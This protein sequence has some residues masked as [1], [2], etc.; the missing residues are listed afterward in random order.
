M[1]KLYNQD[2]LKV[3]EAMAKRGETV[4]LILTDP[5]YE[6]R[7][8]G[9]GI[10][11]KIAL[12]RD[13][14]I[15]FIAHGFDY[16]QCFELFLQIQKIPNMVIFCSNKQILKFLLFFHNKGLSTTLLTWKKLNPPPLVNNKH[17]G[18]LEYLIYVR[19][20]G[21]SFNNGVPIEY[22]QKCF[23]SNLV[24]QKD[25]IHPTQKNLE[26]IKRLIALHSYEG[27][28]VFDPFMGSGVVGIAST[29][30][31]R[32]FIG[33][34]LSPLYFSLSSNRIKNIGA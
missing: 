22:K 20:A 12:H 34:E 31:N 30:L 27:E 15:D 29:M 18:D 8:G 14:K 4:D 19:G 2:C 1:I 33:C 6:L 17:L 9:G 23:S 24:N 7:V 3:M 5:P 25:K 21:A 10:A 13:R 32:S 11:D 26:H 28:V 16:Q